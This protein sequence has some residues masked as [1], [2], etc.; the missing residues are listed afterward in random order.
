LVKEGDANTRYFQI[1]VN[2]R[3]KKNFIHSLHSGDHVVWSHSDKKVVHDHFL[4]HLSS[5]V[6]GSAYSTCLTS[7][8]NLNPW[9]ISR[10]MSQNL[11]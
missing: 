4:K 9:I 2:V 7:D 8:G 11:N 6:P 1:M 5:Y 10:L 3:K